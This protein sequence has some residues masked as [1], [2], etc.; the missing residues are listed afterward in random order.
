MSAVQS[1]IIVSR[2]AN[3]TFIEKRIPYLLVA[4]PSLNPTNELNGNKT[5]AEIA[6]E[7]AKQQWLGNIIFFLPENSFN[8]MSYS[9]LWLMDFLSLFSR[10]MLTRVGEV[11][12]SFYLTIV[13][14]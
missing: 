9:L 3:K 4:I 6:S 10:L 1:L 7:I 13:L 5:L 14:W 2:I 11:A 8:I 12:A